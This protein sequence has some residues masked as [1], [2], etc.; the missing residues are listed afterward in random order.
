MGREADV[1]KQLTFKLAKPLLSGS[2]LI[3]YIELHNAYVGQAARVVR[4]KGFFHSANGTLPNITLVERTLDASRGN[5]APLLIANFDALSIRQTTS[6]MLVANTISVVLG[7]NV[8]IKNATVV[9]SGLKDTQTQDQLLAL[10]FDNTTH[11]FGATAR[12]IQATGTL[13]LQASVEAGQVYTINFTLTNPEVGQASPPVFAEMYESDYSTPRQ[14]RM[15]RRLMPYPYYAV[16]PL[17]VYG[18]YPLLACALTR[19]LAA[20]PAMPALCNAGSYLPAVRAAG[21]KEWHGGEGMEARAVEARAV[22][23]RAVAA[24]HSR[25]H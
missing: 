24:R 19:L 10:T 21:R 1:D 11:D 22:E 9:L 12:W 20:R 23:A 15:V 16:A 18:T 17:F 3:F 5:A 4:I 2:V 7:F 8:D 14:V 13:I 25:R 6:Q